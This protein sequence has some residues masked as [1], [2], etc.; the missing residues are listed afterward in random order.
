MFRNTGIRRCRYCRAEF[1]LLTIFDSDMQAL[2]HLP[3][4]C[5]LSQYHGEGLADEALQRSIRAVTN[6][7]MGFSCLWSVPNPHKRW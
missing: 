7:G 3:A 4:S 1:W 5:G 6:S 2:P